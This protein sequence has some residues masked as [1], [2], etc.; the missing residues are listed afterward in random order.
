MMNET[1]S[2]FGNTNF[3]SADS[4]ESIDASKIEDATGVSREKF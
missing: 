2:D 1:L 4:T 3:V